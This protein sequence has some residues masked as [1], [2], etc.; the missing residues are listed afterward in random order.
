MA[1]ADMIVAY[2]TAPCQDPSHIHAVVTHNIENGN[3]AWLFG[4]PLLISFESR[5]SGAEL[6]GK[7]WGRVKPFVMVE[8]TEMTKNCNVDEMLK[9]RIV[10]PQG[11]HIGSREELNCKSFLSSTS[12]ETLAD[13]VGQEST[14]NFVFFALEWMNVTTD[15][16]HDPSERNVDEINRIHYSNFDAMTNHSSYVEYQQRI[17]RFNGA[18]AVTLDQCFKSF[19]QPEKLDDENMWYCTHCKM[20]VRAMKTVSLW[21]LPNILVIHLKRFE[22]RNSFSRDKIGVLVDF[23]LEGFDLRKH[24]ASTA[25]VGSASSEFVADEAPLLYDLFGGEFSFVCV[26]KLRDFDTSTHFYH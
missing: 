3:G 2:E 21:R 15:S 23:P 11:Q 5:L 16:S 14:E 25:F 26:N 24:S 12:N 6:C 19:T 8:S 20:H 1:N 18:N 9:I 7:L 4:L 22:Y 13:L 10:N 17:R